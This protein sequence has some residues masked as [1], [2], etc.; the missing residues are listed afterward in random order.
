MCTTSCS[1]NYR[2]KKLQGDSMDSRQSLFCQSLQLPMNQVTQ[3]WS[4]NYVTAWSTSCPVCNGDEVEEPNMIE[5]ARVCLGLWAPSRVQYNIC[6]A[7][8]HGEI[9]ELGYTYACTYT[10][11]FKLDIILYHHPLVIEVILLDVSA[12][13]HFR[14]KLLLR[15]GFVYQVLIQHKKR[16]AQL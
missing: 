6:W 9:K 16:V 8:M 13:V 4:I 7:C 14:T 1:K 2:Y 10:C 5:L 3:A 12:L 15:K 11:K